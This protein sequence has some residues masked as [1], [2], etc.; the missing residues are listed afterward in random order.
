MGRKSESPNQK[1]IFYGECRRLDCDGGRTPGGI[2]DECWGTGHIS[3]EVT[4]CET[5]LGQG[6]VKGEPCPN[7]ECD[8]GE[9]YTELPDEGLR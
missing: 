6:Y 8:G 7:E 9:V 4:T 3:Y 5:C 1:H 2:C